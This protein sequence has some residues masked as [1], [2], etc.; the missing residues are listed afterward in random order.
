MGAL[1]EKA[2]E[3]AECNS[4]RRLAQ[5]TSIPVPCFALVPDA[6]DAH[7]IPGRIENVQRQIAGVA[8]RNNQFAQFFLHSASDKWVAGQDTDG[9]EHV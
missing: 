1:Q 3:M 2:D 4:R 6:Q 8:S 9:I 5:G 7:D